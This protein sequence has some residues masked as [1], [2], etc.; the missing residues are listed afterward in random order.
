MFGIGQTSSNVIAGLAAVACLGVA[1]AQPDPNSVVTEPGTYEM[2]LPDDG[3]L[4]TLVIPDGYSN[5]EPAPLIVSLHY[6][7]N[8]TPFYGRG[9]LDSLIEP[10][11]RD[12]KAI[13][14]APDSAAGSWANAQAEE[15]V[16]ALVDHIEATYN[17][18]KNRTLLTGYSMGGM[19]TWYM[20]AR[21][22]DRF[23]AAIAMAGRPQADLWSFNWQTPLYVIHSTADE[24]IDLAPTQSAVE[25]LQASGA[26]VHL[27]VIDEITHFQW[28]R[29]R[30]HLRAA[31]PWIEATWGD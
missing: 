25:Q 29:Y 13:V 20:A 10:A 3:S 6:G 1:E 19:G 17:I 30:S 18:D 27:T 22:P 4:Y 12:L 16:L 5:Q 11:L 23:R 8:V 9:L 24:L 7:G 21:H 15:Q 2:T 28:P 31:I 14:V 26:P